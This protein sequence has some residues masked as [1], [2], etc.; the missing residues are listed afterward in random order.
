MVAYYNDNDPYCA[1]HLREMIRLG[2]LAPGDV[3]DRSIKEVKADDLRKYNSVHLFAGMG[4]WPLAAR[5]AGWPDDRPLWSGSCPCQP[6]SVAGKRKGVDDPRHLW[7]EMLRLIR[8]RAPECIVGEQVASKDGAVW[9]SG[10]R[11]DLEDQDHA[12][13]AADI[14]A[15]GFSA[16]HIRQRLWW[17]AWSDKRSGGQGGEIVQGGNKRG[18]AFEGAG[19]G[20]GCDAI[21]LGDPNSTRLSKRKSV[22]ADYLQNR[23]SSPAEDFSSSGFT[24]GVDAREFSNESSGLADTDGLKFSGKSSAGNECHDRENEEARWM[25]ESDSTRPF[26]RKS[27]SASTRYGDPSDATGLWDRSVFFPC[28]DGKWRRVPWPQSGIFPLAYGLPKGFR[29]IDARLQRLAEM[30]GLSQTS[31]KRAKRFRLNALRESGNAIVLIQATE[32]LSAAMEALEEFTE[33]E[34]LK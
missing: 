11:S 23:I 33:Q 20:G 4:G 1:E 9:L 14:P 5:L 17:L 6:F 7:P 15:A 29:S 22:G 32:I 25:G 26:P 10:V 31:L 24:N 28:S 13:W 8:E 18:N 2:I 27:P 30:A 12:V 16:P 34:E 21:G 19:S 3:D